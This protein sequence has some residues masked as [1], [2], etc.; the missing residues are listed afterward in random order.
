MDTNMLLLA[1]RL[2]RDVEQRTTSTGTVVLRFVLAQTRKRKQGDQWIDESHFYDCVYLGKN[3]DRVAKYLIKG[4]QVL[5]TAELHQARWETKDGQKRSK[6]EVFVRE[7]QLLGSKDDG[8]LEN[9]PDQGEADYSGPGFEEDI[10][11]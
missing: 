3:V 9:A 6:L 2:V 5:V 10:P 7:L 11:F 8:T 1:G 4:K